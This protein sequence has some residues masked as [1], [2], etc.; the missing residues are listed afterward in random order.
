MGDVKPEA[1]P[2]R[3]WT[4]GAG[5]TLT[6]GQELV[7]ENGLFRMTVQQDGNVV[8]YGPDGA[9]KTGPNRTATWALNTSGQDSSGFGFDE[10]GFYLL[11][12]DDHRWNANN[13][14]A[15]STHLTLTLQNDGN[16]VVK[17]E[18]GKVVWS[19]DPP[20][21]NAMYDEAVSG[22]TPTLVCPDGADD[23]RG[24][25]GRTLYQLIKDA[26]TS[27]R[28]MYGQL[29]TGIYKSTA[30]PPNWDGMLA[31]IDL[32]EKDGTSVAFTE[33]RKQLDKL[34]TAVGDWKA[35]DRLTVD[36]AQ[37]TGQDATKA[38]ESIRTDVDKLNDYLRNVRPPYDTECVDLPVTDY[39]RVIKESD[40]DAIADRLVE[41]L[42]T[43][44][45]SVADLSNKN[46]EEAKK[47]VPPEDTD[48]PPDPKPDPED[49]GLT[50]YDP[51]FTPYDPGIISP[52]T[53]PFAGTTDASSS[54]DDPF[55]TL[56][57][58]VL[59]GIGS[60]SGTGGMAQGVGN[61]M[62]SM[63]PMAMAPL[64]SSL[65]NPN[66]NKDKSGKDK[67]KGEHDEREADRLAEAIPP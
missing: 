49:P 63:M 47:L 43:V 23:G 41:T 50:P 32:R 57:N 28:D 17:D 37:I 40:R 36:V 62:G 6:T 56:L 34:T 54:T 13:F 21:Y 3:R 38:K 5:E 9:G 8:I 67:H 12:S 61:A 48:P 19:P 27:L 25:D 18:T 58:S 66:L 46:F 39:R 59:G 4:L 55:T 45:K 24:E 42:G 60:P 44:E 51:N 30:L 53:E 22:Y 2:T 7:S 29:G 10:S 14:T 31:D 52:Y 16:L 64:L 35:T 15:D 33:Y 26:E 11:T 20:I 65:M 1:T